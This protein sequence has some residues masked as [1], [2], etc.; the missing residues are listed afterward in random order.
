MDLAKSW[1]VE[2][3]SDERGENFF[4]ITSAEAAILSR[5]ETKVILRISST[6]AIGRFVFQGSRELAKKSKGEV[7]SQQ[8]FT[9][10]CLF[11]LKVRS[12]F[13]LDSLS[14]LVFCCPL[15]I[16][17]T[18]PVTT[19]VEELALPV[20]GGGNGEINAWAAPALHSFVVDYFDL[21]L[22][23]AQFLNVLVQKL[24]DLSMK[25]MII[26]LK[27][28]FVEADFGHFAFDQV[29]GYAAK[30]RLQV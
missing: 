4:D 19:N 2:F 12:I 3:E 27:P 24:D 7:V 11:P 5:N 1:K 13:A 16:A 9:F 8:F 21:L 20:I 28:L 6:A 22:F 26:E 15:A 10:T 23:T 14:V 29:F 30:L 18:W 17:N 25:C